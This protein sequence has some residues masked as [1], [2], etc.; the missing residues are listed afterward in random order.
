MLSSP[1]EPNGSETAFGLHGEP[2]CPEELQHLDRDTVDTIKGTIYHRGNRV[3]LDE[4]SGLEHTKRRW[5]EA[6]RLLMER[7]DLVAGLLSASVGLLSNG[8]P[9]TGRCC[10]FGCLVC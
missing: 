7:P 9:G 4:I 3:T 5:I 8:P 2:Q 10:V 6:V 1:S